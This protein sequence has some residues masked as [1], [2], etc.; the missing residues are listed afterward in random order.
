MARVLYPDEGQRLAY[1]PASAAGQPL[2]AANGAAVP[3]FADAALT[4]PADIQSTG[5]ASLGG[6]LSVGADSLI[7]QFL[8]PDPPPDRLYVPRAG[9]GA[10]ELRPRARYPIYVATSSSE[11]VNLVRGQA[12]AYPRRL[13]RA[14]GRV[15]IGPGTSDPATRSGAT[16]DLQGPSG[17]IT[18]RTRASAGGANAQEWT[19]H[20]GTT[21]GSM[22]PTGKLGARLLEIRAPDTSTVALRVYGGAGP[23]LINLVEI[24]DAFG[25]PITAFANAGGIYHNDQ[26]GIMRGVFGPEGHRFDIYGTRKQLG[27]AEFVTLGPPG[28]CLD[29]ATAAHETWEGSRATSVGQWTTDFGATAITTASWDPT[30]NPAGG[31]NVLRFTQGLGTSMGARTSQSTADAVPT[32]PGMNVTA[33][34]YLRAASATRSLQLCAQHLSSTGSVLSQTNGTAATDATSSW[35]Q[36][37]VNATV[38]ASGAYVALK[39]QNS[40]GSMGANEVHYAAAPGFWKDT[41]TSGSA[42]P[43]PSR[44]W[45][46]PLV[47]QPGYGTYTGAR[48]ADR[49]WRT[50]TPATANQRLY[51]LDG[52]LGTAYAPKLVGSG[53]SSAQPRWVGM[54]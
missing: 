6:V 38:P 18:L 50:G 17:D 32:S 24:T 28:N 21:V 11:V 45:A 48:T 49:V 13:D 12:D 47:S 40:T 9:G 25:A 5:G 10:F 39:V 41:R 46:P 51:V 37:S 29:F 33:L 35:T 43:N 2:G 14:D 31:F 44:Q 54:A 42:D 52:V 26:L 15:V 36:Y 30:D 1:A 3:V 20:S 4:T 19:D 27:L 23:D 34:I 22:S 7:P 8:S 53:G 16:V